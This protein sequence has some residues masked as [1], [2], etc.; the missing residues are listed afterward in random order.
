[1]ICRLEPGRQQ[2]DWIAEGF[3]S[4]TQTSDEMSI[5]CK[6]RTLE[7]VKCERDWRLLQ[8]VGPL[9]FSEIGILSS[10]SS[11]LAR[12]QISIFVVSTF[13]TDYLMLKKD[14]LSQAIS[15]LTEAGYEI[16]ED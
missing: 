14:K 7:N 10:L 3:S 4:I 2:P 16:L 15:A 13:D 5:V 1:M 11:I 6:Q 12:E 9:E 8:V